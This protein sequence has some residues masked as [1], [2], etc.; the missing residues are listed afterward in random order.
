MVDWFTMIARWFSKMAANLSG[1]GF[2]ERSIR[3]FLSMKNENNSLHLILMVLFDDESYST[4]IFLRVKK[5]EN[6]KHEYT[7]VLTAWFG[8]E[9]PRYVHVTRPFTRPR[10]YH[11]AE[12]QSS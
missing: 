12:M 11:E 10:D 9:W 1:V 3:D 7:P 6:R 4:S 2:S 5:R 8:T